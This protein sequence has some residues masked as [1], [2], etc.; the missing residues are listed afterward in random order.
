M[1]KFVIVDAALNPINPH[2]LVFHCIALLEG[3]S[4]GRRAARPISG[5]SDVALTNARIDT[6]TDRAL[7]PLG[8]TI[9]FALCQQCSPSS[10]A[11]LRTRIG[12][13]RADRIISLVQPAQ[14]L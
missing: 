6:P 9:A 11:E 13:P 14:H 12:Q 2:E 3:R 8:A 5:V 10:Y 1:V 7:A 4:Y